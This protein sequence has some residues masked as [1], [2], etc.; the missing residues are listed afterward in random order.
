MPLTRDFKETVQARL[1][2]DPQFRLALYQEALSSFLEGDLATGKAMLRD[3]VNATIGFQELAKLTH[4]TPKSLMRMLS[5]EGN[6]QANNIFAIIS[7]LGE[8]DG[9]SVEIVHQKHAL[10]G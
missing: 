2:S 4:K 1:Q 3:Y 9:Y 7:V 10:T 6:P 5:P 8:H